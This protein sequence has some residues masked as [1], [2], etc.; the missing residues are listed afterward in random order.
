MRKLLLI[1]I[2]VVLAAAGAAFV[3]LRSDDHGG[4]EGDVRPEPAVAATL[5]VPAAAT[6]QE[7][8][9]QMSAEGVKCRGFETQD[10]PQ[11]TLV[12]F[13]KCYLRSNHENETDIYVCR[14]IEACELWVEALKRTKGFYLLVG[15]TWILTNASLDELQDAQAALGGDVVES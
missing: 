4:A 8:V 15:D 2:V 1:A 13:G 9:D 5:S 14:S 11:E 10:A 12:D 6:A 3:V 7:L